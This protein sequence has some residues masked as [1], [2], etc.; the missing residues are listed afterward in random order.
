MEQNRLGAMRLPVV[1]TTGLLREA[2]RKQQ[3]AEPR[4][5]VRGCSSC[6]C[7]LKTVSLAGNHTDDQDI[8]LTS[9]Q[10]ASYVSWPRIL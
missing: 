1:S 10:Q 6:G 3:G 5:D 4:E 8:R 7:I 2:W 9:K